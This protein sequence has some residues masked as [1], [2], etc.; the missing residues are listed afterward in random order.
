MS[1]FGKVF[2]EASGPRFRMPKGEKWTAQE[3]GKLLYFMARE[4]PKDSFEP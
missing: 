1:I 3:T 2:D 4:G